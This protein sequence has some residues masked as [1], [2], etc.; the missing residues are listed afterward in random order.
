MNSVFERTLPALDD[1]F[2]KSV[3]V[4]GGVA[5]LRTSVKD[6]LLEEKKTKAREQFALDLLT[7]LADA[8]KAE[9]P[10]P[11]VDEEVGKLFEELEHNLTEKGIAKEKYFTQIGKTEEVI[12]KEMVPHAERNIKT[13]LLLAEIAKR[14]KIEP[15]EDTIKE[16]VTEFLRQYKSAK[17]AEKAI[18]PER[19]YR[20]TEITLRNQL[21]VEFLI[22]VAQAKTN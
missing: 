11:A 20:Y 5:D 8:L 10:K 17:D 21:V 9:I 4:F 13:Q 7:H 1:A 19:L 2:A 6:G 18:D 14:E 16:R 22:N 12:K 15:T 3:G